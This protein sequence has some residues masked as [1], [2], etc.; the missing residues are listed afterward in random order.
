VTTKKKPTGA[1]QGETSRHLPRF[2]VILERPAL[3]GTNR[4][5]KI[6]QAREHS[7]Q[8]YREVKDWIRDH[9][10]EDQLVDISEPTAFNIL[11][12]T[13]S[14]D[15]ASRLIEAPHV[16]RVDSSSDIPLDLRR[17]LKLSA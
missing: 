12:V 9:E 16:K 4:A 14:A 7:L 2:Q 6:H 11:F 5:E 13:G 17:P 1:N 15:A 8:A 10:L 3:T